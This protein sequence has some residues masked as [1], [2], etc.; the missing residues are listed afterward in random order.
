MINSEN[1][2][3]NL[4]LSELG[5]S[6][7]VE[8][9]RNPRKPVEAIFSTRYDN[10]RRYSLK[11]M[12]PSFAIKRLVITP[13]VTTIVTDGFTYAYRIPSDS[14]GVLGIG[15]I[16]DRLN[17]YTIEGNILYTDEYSETGITLRY[18][19]D[20]TD[21]TKYSPE[22][23]R[24]FSLILAKDVCMQV[25]QSNE[26]LVYLDQRLTTEMSCSA[27][28]NSQENRPIKINRSKFEKSKFT[29]NPSFEVKL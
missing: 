5:S 24:I 25:L 6:I 14:V 28:M 27:S 13:M 12:K 15:T 26:K 9:I 4:A 11:L 10:S 16:Q 23:I 1:G 8:N 22:F 17:N 19:K 2:I 3:C 29:K 7:T 21:V 20:E 18:V